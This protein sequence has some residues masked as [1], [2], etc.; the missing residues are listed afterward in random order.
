MTSSQDYN[1]FITPPQG[2]KPGPSTSKTENK[3]ADDDS[4]DDDDGALNTSSSSHDTSTSSDVKDDATDGSKQSKDKAAVKA[5]SEKSDASKKSSKD[6]PTAVSDLK[7]DL[8]E[9]THGG[10]G[11]REAEAAVASAGTLTADDIPRRERSPS[12]ASTTS[13][14]SASTL[15]IPESMKKKYQKDKKTKD[16]K[17]KQVIPRPKK[18]NKKKHPP[19]H[20]PRPRGRPPKNKTGIAAVAKQAANI[21]KKRGRKRGR[22]PGVLKAK[23]QL[24]DKVNAQCPTVLA[25]KALAAKSNGHTPSEP[26]KRQSPDLPSE[27]ADVAPSSPKRRKESPEAEGAIQEST[28]PQ[29]APPVL[30]AV[31]ENGQPD[32]IPNC[33]SPL[34][35]GSPPVTP[36]AA[37]VTNNT[38]PPGPPAPSLPKDLLEPEKCTE[39]DSRAFWTPPPESKAA[40]DKVMI[41]DV[42][43]NM[44]T[45]TVRESTTDT[46]FFKSCAPLS[47]NNDD[48]TASPAKIEANT[49]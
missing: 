12:Q 28:S 37:P 17:K 45:I 9:G 27:S 11:E 14:S 20:V 49:T 42:T 39:E 30:E 7:P 19:G 41:T 23:Q 8:G 10:D 6:A 22:P 29:E 48:V 18:S 26:Q 35:N 47:V 5:S 4:S 40:L 21:V 2:P 44:L 31:V 46:G 38:S 34:E 1:E 3:R 32:V 15:Q 16:K 43:S 24:K 36:S 33:S 25:A 13:S